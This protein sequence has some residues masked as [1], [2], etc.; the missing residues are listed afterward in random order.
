MGG[1][2]AMHKEVKWGVGGERRSR[3][4]DRGQ[5]SLLT[6]INGDPGAFNNPCA[7]NTGREEIT[8]VTIHLNMPTEK[9]HSYLI[10][11]YD[12]RKDKSL[13]Q[14]QCC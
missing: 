8:Q 2:E 10:Y 13:K 1:A 7:S 3:R 4:R 12:S 6:L 9:H 11:M 5:P 14:C